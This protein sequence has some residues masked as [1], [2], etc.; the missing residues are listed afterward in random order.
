MR[1]WL[2]FVAVGMLVLLGCGHAEH[3]AF[4][5]DVPNGAAVG[6]VPDGIRSLRRRCSTHRRGIRR[7]NVVQP[8]DYD[9]HS[10]MDG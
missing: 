6:L 10:R 4:G 2:V 9:A 7:G 5:Y 8:A 3:G 1:I